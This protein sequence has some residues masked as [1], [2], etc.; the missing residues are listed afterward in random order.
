MSRA[1]H[2]RLCP[3]RVQ[4]VEDFY[5]AMMIGMRPYMVS[6]FDSMHRETLLSYPHL[7]LPRTHL[8]LYRLRAHILHEHDALM[9]GVT[10]L[11]DAEARLSA[12]RSRLYSESCCACSLSSLA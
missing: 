10:E 5:A 4:S 3:V 2:V 12:F 7:S 9:A 6:G 8:Q 1:R 11:R